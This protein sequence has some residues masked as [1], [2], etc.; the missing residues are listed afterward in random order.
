MSN[1]SPSDGTNK[2]SS[3]A[4]ELF[5]M[6]LAKLVNVKTI[7]TFA[8]IAVFCTLSINQNVKLPPELFAAVISSIMTYFFTKKVEENKST[9]K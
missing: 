9:K 7:M 5:G 8:I 1:S 2:T 4:W 3:P 6:N